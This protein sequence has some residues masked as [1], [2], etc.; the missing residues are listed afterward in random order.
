MMSQAQLLQCPDC[1][2]R[3]D[4]ASLG[5]VQ[6]FRCEQCGR[7]LKV[8]AQFRNAS[9]AAPTA[10]PADATVRQPAVARIPD[11]ASA[12]EPIDPEPEPVV[13][14]RTPKPVRMSRHN[15]SRPHVPIYWRLLVWIAAIPIGLVIVFQ[16]IARK[17]GWL[18]QNQLID[19]FTSGGWDRF[20]PI[21]QLLPL[22]AFVIAAIVQGSVF[23][24]EALYKRRARL[25]GATAPAGAGAPAGQG[26]TRATGS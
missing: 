1:G 6:T 4:I 11:P 24:I 26:A 3:H 25:A 7:A 8:P 15:P 10:A 17:L 5:D 21:A 13:A 12:P 2:H 23:G 22:A 16:L 20:R 19:A 9:A 14:T 18:T